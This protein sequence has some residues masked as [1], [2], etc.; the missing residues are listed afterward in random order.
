MSFVSC[1]YSLCPEGKY[2]YTS[3]VSI[4]L[5]DDQSPPARVTMTPSLYLHPLYHLP[6]LLFTTLC[7]ITLT[8]KQHLYRSLSTPAC[9]LRYHLLHPRLRLNHPVYLH[10]LLLLPHLLLL[11]LNLSMLPHSL[12]YLLLTLVSVMLPCHFRTHR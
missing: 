8:N 6:H 3:L 1:S 4:A 10:P 9:D 5:E 11:L 7:M 12:L 2:H